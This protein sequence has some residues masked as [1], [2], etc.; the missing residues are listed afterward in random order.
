MWKRSCTIL[1]YYPTIFLE[2]LW[3]MSKTS[4]GTDGFHA[5]NQIRDVQST[6]KE[7]HRRVDKFTLYEYIYLS[8]GC[9]DG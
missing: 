1:S 7:V 5:E 3:K 9:S 4:V 8:D 6:K 2:R